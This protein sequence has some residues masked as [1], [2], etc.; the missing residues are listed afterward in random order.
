VSHEQ[1]EVAWIDFPGAL[2]QELET[3]TPTT[4]LAVGGV[5]NAPQAGRTSAPKNARVRDYRP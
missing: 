5:K 4:T 1:T 2:G 3:L